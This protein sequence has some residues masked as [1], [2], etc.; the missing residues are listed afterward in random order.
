VYRNPW[1]LGN[2]PGYNVDERGRH[3]GTDAGTQHYNM[4]A[5]KVEVAMRCY[6]VDERGCH[7]GTDAETQHYNVSTEKVEVAMR[8][9]NIDERAATRGQMLERSIIT[10]WQRRTR[11][12]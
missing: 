5:E 9:Y 4:S 7:Q 2:C 8:C 10:C 12:R 6:N 3:Q 11:S 1:T